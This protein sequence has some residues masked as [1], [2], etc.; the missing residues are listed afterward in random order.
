MPLSNDLSVLPSHARGPSARSHW[1]FAATLQRLREQHRSGQR[2]QPRGPLPLEK[3]PAGFSAAPGPP[4]AE[5]PQPAKSN[6]GAA[7][8]TRASASAARRP[9]TAKA[10]PCCKLG[11]TS[12]LET[13]TITA[14]PP[15]RRRP[16]SL[17]LLTAN[18]LLLSVPAAAWASA[19]TR[20]LTRLL[21][22][23][24]VWADLHPDPY[25]DLFACAVLAHRR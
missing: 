1:P 16:R 10:A 15:S 19:G 21:I 5:R 11:V 23:H 9:T 13:S 25:Q 7:S 14:R 3:C 8:T 6:P 17:T 22:T 24:R 18:S 4:F 2:A 20:I 12:L